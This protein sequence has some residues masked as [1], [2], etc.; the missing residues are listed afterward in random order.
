MR[1]HIRHL[2]QCLPYSKQAV[3]IR[4]S[5][6]LCNRRRQLALLL[7]LLTLLPPLLPLPLQLLLL[8]LLLYSFGLCCPQN[9]LQ[10]LLL[11][12]LWAHWGRCYSTGPRYCQV[13][14]DW[15]VGLMVIRSHSLT[16][17]KTMIV[18]LTY[19]HDPHQPLTS[20]LCTGVVVGDPE[21]D[22]CNQLYS[23]LKYL[24]A[25]VWLRGLGGGVG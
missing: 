18:F 24:C 6:S 23:L 4:Y 14:Q 19:A 12:S 10:V 5:H 1:I 9:H 8:L 17:R 16:C 22:W 15:V 25:C 21:E 7:S 3:N 20:A 11:N 2:E 13:T